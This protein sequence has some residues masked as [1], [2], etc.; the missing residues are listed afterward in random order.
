MDTVGATPSI[1]AE[2][3]IPEKVVGEENPVIAETQEPKEEGLKVIVDLNDV[4]EKEDSPVK[5]KEFRRRTR[6]S[7][8]NEVDDIDQTQ[9]PGFLAP[10]AGG[11]QKEE[12]P[13]SE[14]ER[15]E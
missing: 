11:A 15:G 14:E 3:E 1:F 4:L 12:I 5:R 10:D 6:R 8:L 7:L 9:E 13:G 2:G